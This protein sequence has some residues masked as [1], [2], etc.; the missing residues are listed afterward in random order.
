MV[1]ATFGKDARHKLRQRW[2][3]TT[4]DP[5]PLRLVRITPGKEDSILATT[6]LDATTYTREDIGTLYHQRWA[7]EELYT[8]AKVTIGVDSFHGQSE[9]NVRQELYAHF[10]L[11]AMTRLFTLPGNG[12]LAEE[13]EEGKQRQTIHFNHALAI[14]AATMEELLLVSS[15]L[16]TRKVVRMAQSIFGMRIRIRPNRSYPRVARPPRSQ[17]TR[18]ARPSC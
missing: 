10:N 11:I 16:V 4:F 13:G 14:V 8:I 3:S 18:V 9:W 7:M 12:L 1:T 15:T 5:I 6:L 2:P 17:W